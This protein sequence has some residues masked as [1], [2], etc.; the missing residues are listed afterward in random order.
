MVEKL[1][2]NH[3]VFVQRFVEWLIEQ[4]EVRG[5]DKYALRLDHIHFALCLTLRKACLGQLG[6]LAVIR[7]GVCYRLP[8]VVGC[9]GTV[10]LQITIEGLLGGDKHVTRLG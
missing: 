4:G 2:L 3:E 1:L 6:L 9:N 10:F 7:G 8:F 5:C